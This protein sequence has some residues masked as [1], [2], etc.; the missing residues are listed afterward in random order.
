M[1]LI[2]AATLNNKISESQIRGNSLAEIATASKSFL[3]MEGD[4]VDFQ[5][6]DIAVKLA[7]N[8]KVIVFAAVLLVVVSIVAYFFVVRPKLN[9]KD[10]QSSESSVRT[11]S[12]SVSS[13]KASTSKGVG[14][15]PGIM[16]CPELVVPSSKECALVIPDRAVTS[17]P[18]HIS[19]LNGGTV[20][21][22]TLES[23]EPWQVALKTEKGDLLAKCCAA[24]LSTI[25]TPEYHFL[26]ASGEYFAKLQHFDAAAETKYSI[27]LL[28]GVRLYISVSLGQLI[29]FTSENGQLLA[30]LEPMLMSP[31]NSKK[32]GKL[33]L[34]VAPNSDAGL[35]LCAMLCIGHHSR[36]Q[37]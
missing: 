2:Q 27:T 30:S 11:T 7:E 34:R 24:Q 3:L 25:G 17:G 6:P 22:V 16:F 10:N 35:A 29:D 18:F 20:L 31:S 36:L 33:W 23:S 14:A 15:V 5:A 37:K 4:I 28:N 32:D 21:Q 12:A 8:Y 26:K 1:S 19:D 9:S 13:G